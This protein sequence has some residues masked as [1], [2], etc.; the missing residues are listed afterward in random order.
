MRRSILSVAMASALL[1]TACSDDE[2]DGETAQD[3]AEDVTASTTTG[4]AD[5]DEAA[6]C[7]AT[8]RYATT[9]DGEIFDADN[10]TPEELESATTQLREQLDVLDDTLPDAI[11]DQFDLIIGWTEDFLDELAKSG[12]DPAAMTTTEEFSE[13]T[14][15][16]ASDEYQAATVA[17]SSFVLDECG[18]DL[19]GG[20][21][22]VATTVPTT[23]G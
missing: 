10:P 23:D 14:E 8:E 22:G 20:S 18:I 1:A 11:D 3:D 21:G 13:L 9:L 16:A 19:G 12:Y 2:G 6:F 7:V 17:V 15:Q 5:S 4:D